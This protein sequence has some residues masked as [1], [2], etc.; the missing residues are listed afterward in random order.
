MAV[1]GR[2]L[3]L[4]LSF[5][6]PRLHLWDLQEKKIVKQYTGHA[7][8]RFLIKASFGGYKNS[9][10]VSGSEGK[11]CGLKSSLDADIYLWHRK[12]GNLLAVIEGHTGTVNCVNWNPVDT[13]MMVSGKFIHKFVYFLKLLMIKQ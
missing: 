2:Y 6:Y 11:S 8:E 7:Q 5:K 12:L 4:N 10:I 3:L 9:F 1:D 13:H